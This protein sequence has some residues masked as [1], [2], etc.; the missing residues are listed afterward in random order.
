MLLPL[1]VVVGVSGAVFE[2]AL[3]HDAKL[4]VRNSAL[5]RKAVLVASSLHRDKAFKTEWVGLGNRLQQCEDEK[6]EKCLGIA[7]QIEGQELPPRG[8]SNADRREAC[9]LNGKFQQVEEFCSLLSESG[10]VQS[11]SLLNAGAETET[12]FGGQSVGAG[13]LS[14]RALPSGVSTFAVLAKGLALLQS[15]PSADYPAKRSSHLVSDPPAFVFV[16]VDHA[17]CGLRPGPHFAVDGAT[18]PDASKRLE[19]AEF[20]RMQRFYKQE[21]SKKQRLLFEY[22]S[23]GGKTDVLGPSSFTKAPRCREQ[24][25]DILT[26]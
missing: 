13:A 6:L 12:L 5:L 25:A 14:T 8:K 1:G 15:A 21:L 11:W 17:L 2:L 16:F 3:Q 26:L 20:T 4:S 23:L 24:S 22:R 19:I 7:E 18:E 10:V 9:F